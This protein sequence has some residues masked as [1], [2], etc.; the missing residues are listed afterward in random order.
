M[1]HA[2]W[3][4]SAEANRI[5][6]FVDNTSRVLQFASYAFDIS[7]ADMLLTLLAGGCICVPSDEDRQSNLIGAINSLQANWACLTP[8]VTRI[9]DPKTVSSIKKLVLCGEAIAPGDIAKWKPHVHLLNLYGPAE[10]AILTTL[11]RFVDDEKDPNK[12]GLPTSAV[13]WIADPQDHEKLVPVGTVGELLV[14]SPI[15][16]REYIGDPVKTA[17]S[18]L[19]YPSWLRQIRS[20]ATRRLYRTG[21]LVQY[22]DDGSMRYIGRKD[23]QVKLR[24]QRVELGEVEFHLRQ[25]FPG[26]RDAI[27]EV[28]KSSDD[29]PPALMA[30]I[31]VGD[32]DQSPEDIES[33]IF[34]T[35]DDSFKKAVVATMSQLDG[36]L[37]VFMVPT[38]FIPLAHIPLTKTGKT[39]RRAVST[40]AADLTREQISLFTSMNSVKN[41]PSSEAE[42]QFQRLFAEVL[43]LGINDIGIDDHFFRLGGDSIVAMTLIPKARESGYTIN[44]ADVFNHPKLSDLAAASMKITASIDAPIA[45]F[46]LVDDKPGQDTLVEFAAEQCR[47]PVDQV[48]D[49]YPCT[50][51]QAG[52]VALSAKLADHYIA[53][54]EYELADSVDMDRFVAAWNATAVANTILR[55]RIIE[56]DSA[57]FLQVVI[58][59]S[60]AWQT[61]ENETEFEAQIQTTKMEMGDQLV[62]FALIKPENDS[63]AAFNFKFHLTLHHALYDGA[64]L[65]K[66]WQQVQAAYNGASP[67][68][69]P[70]NR[71][72]EYM[73]RTDGADT[74]WK[75]EFEGLSAP[76]FPSLPSTRYI[77]DPSSSLE[78]TIS[79]LDDES[80]E[81][82]AST[83]IRLAWAVVMSC[84]TDSEDVVYGLTVN[85]R[86]APVAGIEDITGPTFATFP[87]RTQVRS[88]DTV[89]SAL[90][91][92]QQK[93]V[94]MMPFQ[95]FGMQNMR[96]L[97]REAAEACD[98]QCHLA[99][100]APGSSAG[101]ELLAN[102][103]TKHDDYGAFSNYAF[104]L[105]CHLPAK[106]ESDL[107]ITVNYDKNIVHQT[108]ATRMVHQFE[109]VLRQLSR[110]Q[111]QSLQL[112]ELDLVSPEDQQQ[113][114]I[115]N[116]AVPP[117]LDACL[118]DLVLQYAVSRP[119]APAISA[120]DG[121]MTFKELDTASAI[122][123]QQLQSLGIR[124]G[125]L[126]PLLF[127]R[128]KWVITTMIALHRIGA[129]C[130]NI[131]P[132][133]PRGRI[134]DILDRTEAKLILTSPTHRN[135]MVFENITAVTVPIEGEQP[136]PEDLVVPSV[137]PH[138]VAF[139]VFTSGSTGKPKGIVM[140][141]VNLATSIEGYAEETRLG[142]NTRILHFASYAF[143]ACIYE[144]F[145]ALMYGGC[146]CIPSEFD[147][148][149]DIVP[150]I[151]KH[152]VN[153]AL[154]TPSFLSLLEPES[155][156]SMRTIYLGGEA[157]TQE[158]V[159]T[160]ASRVHL[161]SAY[162]PAESSMCAALHITD[163]AW[164][165]GSLGYVTGGVG[166]IAM[167]S[168]PSRLAP[169]GAPGVLVVEG[170]IITRGYLHDPEKTAAAYLTNPPWLQ[171]FRNAGSDSPLYVCG[172]LVQ[173]QPNGT[174]RFLGRRDT[175]VKLRGQ[176][177]ELGEV[178][179]HLRRSFPNATDVVA[180]VVAPHGGPPALM[181]F[182]ANGADL[183]GRSTDNLFEDPSEEFL[184]QCAVATRRISGVVPSYMVPAVFLQLSKI[185]RNSSEKTDRKRLRLE[186]AKLSQEQ[187]QGFSGGRTAKRLP[188]TEQEKLVQS[189]WAQ[190][191]KIP[192]DDVGA[193][194]D[195]FHL[196]GD[197]IVAIR[198]AGVA[199]RQG[200][201]LPVSQIFRYPILS[202]LATVVTTLA[203]ASS[204][205]KYV[206][207]SLLGI[208]SLE[209][210][211]TGQL[212]R[213]SPEY[214]AQDVEDILP[215]T[216][217]QSSLLRGKNVTYSRLHLG[218]EVDPDRLEAACHALVRKHAILRTI[219]VPYH[220][221]ILQVVLRDVSFQLAHLS[222]SEDLWEYSEKMCSQDHSS[223]IQY[224]ALHFQPYLISRSRSDHMLI[225]RMTHAQYDGGS[226]P[227]LSKDLFSAYDG[228]QLQPSS[229][230]FAHYLRYRLSQ[231]S[232]EAH[233]FWREYLGNAEMTDSQSL[234]R[235]PRN[236]GEKEFLVKP[237]RE[238]PAPS[239][240]EGITMASLVK[241]AWSVVLAR[242]AQ[243]KD[244][245]FG[246][247][248]NGR[249]A[250]LPD[251]D[252]ISGPCITFSP[253]RV[254]MREDWAVTDLLKH[255]QSQYVRSLPFANMDFRDIRKNATA[256]SPDTDFGSVL[257]HQDG[258]I[259]LTG[260]VND[261]ASQ[262][263]NLDLGIQPQFHVVTYPVDGKLLVQFAVSSSRVH[264]ED[265]DRIIDQFCQVVS[266]FSADPLARLEL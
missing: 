2:S 116:A 109:H 108:E 230:S 124:K 162:G 210:F 163:S 106:N 252:S 157:I 90:A 174:L 255:V 221:E 197:S 132:T 76:I 107:I 75:S 77:P 181:A 39:D 165:L 166:W 55:T 219:F 203:S 37:P 62:H 13:C 87:V 188:E 167:P 23:T 143:D 28:I 130:V 155:V 199:R 164:T 213:E 222:C 10:C 179:H 144:I 34:G 43:G 136:R 93:T 19:P 223:P 177:I 88:D 89:Q 128:S 186:A 69:Q 150:F 14:E 105:V 9:M 245:V 225:I 244:I 81:Y 61:F 239:T 11:N 97:S 198:L 204:G 54:F 63:K 259:D 15:V 173:Y 38:I 260:S 45:P 8:S 57:G 156:P 49:I 170:S 146:I 246:H 258:N 236:D 214:K 232:G 27:A 133:H 205:E 35:P 121:E 36:V 16:G 94:A 216:E 50:P 111:S 84:Y 256:W 247:I 208:T 209:D 117:P 262:W 212:A 193:D 30:F 59:D 172:D 266:D 187:I 180:E 42:H 237:L 142:E 141:H 240:P 120:W 207:G 79:A 217:L 235:V 145:S 139:L 171:P 135:L 191:F 100:Q 140:E 200:V 228:N 264:P 123:A 129:A 1:S 265:A 92:I 96:H 98:F 175:Q 251:V 83:A 17:A 231:K 243:R 32:S 238:I 153:W 5:G 7:I 82:T 158:N 127:D 254:A 242:A 114:A 66:L 78:H 184:A 29:R 68:P 70:Y 112:G 41:A 152:Q 189:L 137:R 6:L 147:R 190:A 227:L 56:M 220:S 53:T 33:D 110:G 257:T 192:L 218:T 134:Q 104:V 195:F 91:A 202:E 224:G 31:H 44:M 103:R 20:H 67:S 48:E 215:T 119:N 22:L 125:S 234:C 80:S 148:M 65:P 18:F 149:N 178:E 138:D 168:D 86:S 261:V 122:L 154:L 58:R 159:R 118:H 95:Q 64:S 182:I 115:W 47:V 185:P 226:F 161:V 21:D 3:C 24:G 201:H 12:I 71:F 46:A 51:L 151:N 229:P 249:D 101:N 74:F 183:E 72:I 250:P 99:V 263:R 52:L 126:V 248:I 131:D 102:A 211:F 194:D 85:G 241:A 60:I 176:R 26:A 169:I 73:L 233:E 40:A 25:T 113:L 206:P 253:F 160:W 196:G 4:T